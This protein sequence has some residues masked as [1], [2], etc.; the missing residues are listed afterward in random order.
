M[1]RACADQ[2]GDGQTEGDPSHERTLGS[3]LW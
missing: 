3:N 1:R 2:S